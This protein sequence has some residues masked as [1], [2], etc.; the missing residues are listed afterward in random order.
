MIRLATVAE[1]SLKRAWH[2]AAGELEKGTKFNQGVESLLQVRYFLIFY[3]N[4]LTVEEN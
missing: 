1:K 2:V 3:G 4:L